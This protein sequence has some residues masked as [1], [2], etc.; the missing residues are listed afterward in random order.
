[1]EHTRQGKEAQQMATIIA[2]PPGHYIRY[3]DKDR[4][5][6]DF[7]AVALRIDKD[8]F[9]DVLVLEGD[10]CVTPMVQVDPG[11]GWPKGCGTLEQLDRWSAEE[12][13]SPPAAAVIA[14]AGAE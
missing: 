3:V 1:L 10:G 13:E 8:G 7:P 6:T 11:F 2:A 12:L 5:S 9:G 4:E 14:D